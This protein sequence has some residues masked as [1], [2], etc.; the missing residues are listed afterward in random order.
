MYVEDFQGRTRMERLDDLLSRL[1]SVR[2][3]AYGA[4]VLS[5][6]EAGPSLWIHINRDVA[7]VHY[8]PEDGGAGLQPTGMSPAGCADEVHFVQTDGGEA[9][10]FTMLGEALVEVDAAYAAAG[11]FLH[12]PGPPRSITWTAL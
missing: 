11:E 5:H 1:G 3:G 6:D 12:D 10:S 2:K 8:F 4:F 7:Y 9:D